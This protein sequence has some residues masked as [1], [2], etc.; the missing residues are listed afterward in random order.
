MQRIPVK[1][2]R[3]PEYRRLRYVRY[4]DDFLLG[5]S[6][7]REEAEAIKCQLTGFMRDNLKLELS[8]QKTLITHARSEAAKFL[9]YEVVVLHDDT[10]RDRRGRRAINGVV[11]LKVPPEVVRA[12]CSPYMRRGKPMHR[13]ERTE[14]DA[15]SI[16]AQY[17]Q[18]YRG[19]VE[20]YR[21]AYDLSTKLARLKWVMEASLTKTL[22]HKL[23]IS[24]TQVYRRYQ[25][26]IH[27]ERGPYKVLKVVV[28]RGEKRPLVAQW[29]GISLAWD[30]DAVLDEMPYRVWND[31]GVELLQR[32]LADQC[33]LCGSRERVQVHWA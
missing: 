15:F 13:K 33:E 21:L 10:K 25:T 4:A 26:T 31:S 32:L 14:N 23:R 30:K 8:E 20:Y 2:P 5:F 11:G 18:E 29:G 9:G 16:V 27:T 17:Q 1:D 28:E 24:V 7:P 12:K 6:G 19:I 3:A 22:A